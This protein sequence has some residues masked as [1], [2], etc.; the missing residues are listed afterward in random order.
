MF[1]LLA[2]RA[3]R[4][5]STVAMQSSR[6]ALPN[7]TAKVEKYRRRYDEIIDAAAA[8]FAEKGYHG[9]STKDIADRLGIRQGSLY[10][11]FASKESALEEVC[12]KGVEGFVQGI[13]NV[14]ADGGGGE[15]QLRAAVLNHL[16]PLNTRP[17]YVRVF[18]RDRHDLPQSSRRKIGK[19]SRQYESLLE[20]LFKAGVERGDF[21]AGLDCR[22]ATLAMLGMCNAAANWYAEGDGISLEALAENFAT[23]ILSGTAAKNG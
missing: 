8:V 22:L 3:D 20:G 2:A 9:A 17:T 14:L 12:Q 11:Y 1:V 4:R 13:E 19:A 15:T 7:T 6:R 18:L 21:R 23:L 10:Y 5:Y 16:E